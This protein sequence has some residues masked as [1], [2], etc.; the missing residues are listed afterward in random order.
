MRGDDDPPSRPEGCGA[1]KEDKRRA[2]GCHVKRDSS[3][4]G[5]VR[6]RTVEVSLLGRKQVSGRFR[7]R[8]IRNAFFGYGS[9]KAFAGAGSRRAGVVPRIRRNLRGQMADSTRVR[10][11]LHQ[12][13]RPGRIEILRRANSLQRSRGVHTALLPGPGSELFPVLA[14]TLAGAIGRS[15]EK[16]VQPREPS[17]AAC[18]GEHP[19]GHSFPP[20]IGRFRRNLDGAEAET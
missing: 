1:G 12:A 16:P 7:R 3:G 8:F 17:S 5:P 11:A 2:G 10:L 6:D 15:P 9:G 18:A 14:S 4:L 13:S 20:V 19:A